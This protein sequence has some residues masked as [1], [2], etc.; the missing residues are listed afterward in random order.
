MTDLEKLAREW[1]ETKDIPQ[2]KEE[3][4]QQLGALLTRV[5][6]VAQ[7]EARLD[8]HIRTCHKPLIQLDEKGR[9]KKELR[10]GD[11]WACDRLVDLRRELEEARK[12]GRR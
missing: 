10:C 2:D 12:E 6:R 4:F 3:F 11:D 5:V 1:W 8:E 7:A 9:Y